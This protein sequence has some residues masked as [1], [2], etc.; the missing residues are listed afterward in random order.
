MIGFLGG[1][2]GR[3]IRAPDSNGSIKVDDLWNFFSDEEEEEAENR[4]IERREDYPFLEEEEVFLYFLLLF[5][6]EGLL[7]SNFSGDD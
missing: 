7:R 3:F 5:W 4:H 2:D 6:G 1:R